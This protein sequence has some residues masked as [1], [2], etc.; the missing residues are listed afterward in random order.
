[1]GNSVAGGAS[2]QELLA[3]SGLG[4]RNASGAEDLLSAAVGGAGSAQSFFASR[5]GLSSSANGLGDLGLGL[6]LVPPDAG[7][8]GDSSYMSG[9]RAAA[10]PT[11]SKKKGGKSAAAAAAAAAA[12]AGNGGDGDEDGGGS[13]RAAAAAAAAAVG[14]IPG[15]GRL[16]WDVGKSLSQLT[17]AKDFEVEGDLIN[18]R[19]SGGK[20]RRR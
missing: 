6:H 20:R 8:L 9:A 17:G 2:L 13:S 3:L 10:A 16:R 4:G 11:K 7:I 1:M 18:I 15:T 19:K 12:G 14:S 5:F